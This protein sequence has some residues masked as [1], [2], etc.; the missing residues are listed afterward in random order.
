MIAITLILERACLSYASGSRPT[1]DEALDEAH[2][3]Y[4]DY[5]IH[6]AVIKRFS[7]SPKKYSMSEFTSFILDHRLR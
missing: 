1:R 2:S 7:G 6:S 3:R 4:R 5:D